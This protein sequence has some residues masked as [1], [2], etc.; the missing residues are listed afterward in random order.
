MRSVNPFFHQLPTNNIRTFLLLS[1]H[2]GGAARHVYC[3]ADLV[4][5]RHAARLAYHPSITSD[6]FT[7]S[8]CITP[9]TGPWLIL[10]VFGAQEW[11]KKMSVGYRA[12]P[13]HK[14]PKK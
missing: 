1:R 11:L 2:E 13:E 10:I 8:N 5:K 7:Q 4:W 12:V 3:I 9:T 6:N 14:H